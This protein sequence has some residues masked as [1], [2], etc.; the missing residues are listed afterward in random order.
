MF[1]CSVTCFLALIF[2]Y[3]PSM[4]VASSII[5]L[6]ED[7]FIV[8]PV[9]MPTL[10]ILHYSGEKTKNSVLFWLVTAVLGIYFVIL[11]VA[12]FTDVFYNVT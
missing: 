4:A 5:Y 11:A 6:L 8:T 10:F 9:F 7:V 2:W 12:Q 1:L 3:D